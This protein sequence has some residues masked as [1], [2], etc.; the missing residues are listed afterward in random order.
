V[1]QAL[2]KLVHLL[3]PRQGW[4]PKVEIR[5]L[6]AALGLLE[7]QQLSLRIPARKVSVDDGISSAVPRPLGGSSG[8]RCRARGAGVRRPVLELTRRYSVGST[9]DPL[10]RLARPRWCRTAS[11]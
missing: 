5:G 3:V 9:H 10:L 6:E 11:A 8:E 1:V 7:G 2:S 4:Y